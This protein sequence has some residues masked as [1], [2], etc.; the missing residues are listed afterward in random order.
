MAGSQSLTKL[1]RLF[2]P[3]MMSVS[4]LP[5]H[6]PCSGSGHHLPQTLVPVSWSLSNFQPAH[7]VASEGSF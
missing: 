6:R 4:S 2:M 7:R 3:I 1:F 5:S